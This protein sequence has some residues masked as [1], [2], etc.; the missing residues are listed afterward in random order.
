MPAS[1]EV[2]DRLARLALFAELS[3]PEL[4]SVAHGYDEE[5]FGEGQ[6]VLRQG[7]SGSNLFVILEGEAVIRRDGEDVT[8][9]GAGE[10]FGEISV[11]TAEPPTADVVAA[12]LLRCLVVPGPEAHRFL[13]E[14]P[15]VMLRIL[16][17]EARRVQ[18]AYEWRA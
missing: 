15:Q 4:E 9:L 8:H 11:L 2:V 1:D 6:R 5:V 13:L 10:V 17:S 14:R 12:T 18:S 16:Q 7:L 3:R